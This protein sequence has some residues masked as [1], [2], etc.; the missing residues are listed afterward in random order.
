VQLI[1]PVHVAGGKTVDDRHLGTQLFRR[2]D[3]PVQVLALRLQ[4][5]QSPA[6]PCQLPGDQAGQHQ[7]QAGCRGGQPAY[8]RRRLEG[9]AAAGA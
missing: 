2:L 8:W 5:L 1:Q 7:Q 4:F 3:R 9:Q 6:V